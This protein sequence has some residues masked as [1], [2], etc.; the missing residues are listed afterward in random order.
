M[1]WVSLNRTSFWSGS[2]FNVGI[3]FI[4]WKQD[5]SFVIAVRVLP[6]QEEIIKIQDQSSHRRGAQERRHHASLRLPP[7]HMLIFCFIWHKLHTWTNYLSSFQDT[8]NEHVQNEVVSTQAN[9]AGRRP[10]ESMVGSQTF[11]GKAMLFEDAH[12]QE[13]DTRGRSCPRGSLSKDAGPIVA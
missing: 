1:W 3:L 11:D 10:T 2:I 6:Q 4:D 5:P 7:H 8:H 9:P 12:E 13:R